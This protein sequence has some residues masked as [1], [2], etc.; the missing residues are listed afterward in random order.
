[1]LNETLP[2]GRPALAS[3]LLRQWIE[4]YELPSDPAKEA[5]LA[6]M[7]A[8]HIGSVRDFM[9]HRHRY[10]TDGYAGTMTVLYRWAPAIMATVS[11]L[12]FNPVLIAVVF[13]DERGRRR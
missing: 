6:A 2:V 9:I 12:T 11:V 7:W 8:A 10:P 1:M 13:A 3:Q 5:A 4:R